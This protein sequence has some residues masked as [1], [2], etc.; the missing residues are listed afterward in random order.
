[1]YYVGWSSCCYKC[2]TGT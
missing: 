1:M 2:F